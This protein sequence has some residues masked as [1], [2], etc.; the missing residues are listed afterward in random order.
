MQITNDKMGSEGLEEIKKFEKI[1]SHPYIV[2]LH[3]FHYLDQS[4]WMIMEFCEAGDLEQYMKVTY[5]NIVYL[6][7]II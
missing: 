3:D 4:F 1:E 7:L 6:F 5:V 2:R